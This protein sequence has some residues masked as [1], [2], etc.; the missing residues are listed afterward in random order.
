V[1]GQWDEC[2]PR[3][4]VTR[5]TKSLQCG[6][7]TLNVIGRHDREPAGMTMVNHCGW[8]WMVCEG[9]KE[10]KHTSLRP[11]RPHRAVQETDE[12]EAESGVVIGFGRRLGGHCRSARGC[13]ITT[14]AAC[15]CG[16]QVLQE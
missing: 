4:V 9:E 6:I 7:Q 10:R 5:R 1:G 11:P 2:V 16:V 14:E 13:R 15:E 8:K 12:S 3:E